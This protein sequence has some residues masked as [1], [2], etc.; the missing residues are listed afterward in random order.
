MAAAEA[1]ESDSRLPKQTA[2]AQMHFGSTS[3]PRETM[4]SMANGDEPSKFPRNQ[5]LLLSN[6]GVKAKVQWQVMV[7]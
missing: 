3:C 4:A 2:V 7:L 1:D 5:D 6:R